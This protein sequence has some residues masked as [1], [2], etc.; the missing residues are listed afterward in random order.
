MKLLNILRRNF[1]QPLIISAVLAIT[2]SMVTV[3]HL[4]KSFF[5]DSLSNKMR[6]L[7]TNNVNPVVNLL[8]EVIYKRFQTIFDYLIT[9]REFLD[10][11]HETNIT[12]E[13]LKDKSYYANYVINLRTLYTNAETS[14]DENKMVWYINSKS[15][16]LVKEFLDNEKLFNNKR[17]KKYL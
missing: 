17:T 15:T 7:K 16:S 9:A 10:N 13:I 6:K 5:R 14:I 1:I 4:S 11:Y 8:Q 3:L 2:L 12:D